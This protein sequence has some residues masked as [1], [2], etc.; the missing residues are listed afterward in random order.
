[1]VYGQVLKMPGLAAIWYWYF[2]QN[3]PLNIKLIWKF[4]LV[5][6]GLLLNVQFKG[7][8]HLFS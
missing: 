4:G 7:S 5:F 2:V 1:M 8:Y 3:M 6:A